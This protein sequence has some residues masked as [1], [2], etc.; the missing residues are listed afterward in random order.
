M[1]FTSIQPFSLTI[2]HDGGP[3]SATVAAAGE[4]DLA[5]AEPLRRLLE[6][7]RRIGHRH[8]SVDASAVTFID[9]TALGVLA[10]VHHQ[11]LERHGTLTLTGVNSR[12]QR[13]LRITGLDDVLF[14]ESPQARIPAS[15]A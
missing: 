3:Y 2:R 10:D 11:F 1:A 12:I 15:V 9:A 13:L 7:Q 5:A 8:V 4:V 6:Q 14:V